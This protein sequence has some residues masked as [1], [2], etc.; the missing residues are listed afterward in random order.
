MRCRCRIVG[1]RRE[2]GRRLRQAARCL[3]VCQS[4]TIIVSTWLAFLGGAPVGQRWAAPRRIAHGRR[5]I[6]LAPGTGRL[7]GSLHTDRSV[8]RAGSRGLPG[9]RL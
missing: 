8:R 3:G 6:H 2:S 4:A 5:C 1:G 9:A 7:A